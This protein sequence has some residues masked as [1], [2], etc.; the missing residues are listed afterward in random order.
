MDRRLDMALAFVSRLTLLGRFGSGTSL[1]FNL[2]E[3]ESVRLQDG[4]LFGHSLPASNGHIDVCGF[5]LK[6]IR[7]SA[8][9]FGRQYRGARSG[10]LVENDVSPCGAIEQRV[11]YK[12]DRF[13]RRMRCEIFEAVLPERIDARIRPDIG[14]V[15][16]EPSQLHIVSMRVTTNPKHSDELVLAA[17]ERALAGIRFIPALG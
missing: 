14:P 10:K 17:I 12:S 15:P 13:D 7:N 4:F 8:H 6:A 3:W 2:F 1:L 11:R 9:L 16:P 5:I